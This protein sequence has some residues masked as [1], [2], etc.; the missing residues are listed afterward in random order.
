MLAA[1]V[2][3]VPVHLVL[4]CC[5]VFVSQLRT[6]PHRVPCRLC[7]GTFGCRLCDWSRYRPMVPLEGREDLD[8]F[9][10]GRWVF[11]TLAN[12]THTNPT[13]AKANLK[14]IWP[15]WA[16]GRAPVFLGGGGTR[17][18]EG[19]G[20]DCWAPDP[21]WRGRRLGHP[22]GGERVGSWPTLAKPT[23]AIPSARPT[24][25]ILCF[26]GLAAFG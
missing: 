26:S 5:K 20:L 7:Q 3:R 22:K 1:F 23:L 21:E 12:S 11:S 4:L 15:S 10:W 18:P 24:G 17:G 25:Q 16:K 9:D 19:W 14:N 13:W 2:T 8:Q 6:P